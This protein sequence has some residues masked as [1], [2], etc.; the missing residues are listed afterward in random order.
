MNDAYIMEYLPELTG[1]ERLYVHNLMAGMAREQA[2]VFTSEYRRKRK[3][4]QT[5]LLA[6]IV[7]LV[8]CPG[9]QRFWLGET[10]M[11]FLFLFT[12]GLF[13]MGT[14]IDLAT[15]KT[16]ARC[17]NQK[18]SQKIHAEVLLKA[19]KSATLHEEPERVFPQLNRH[20]SV[21]GDLIIQ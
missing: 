10:G 3:D 20:P 18:V 9:F 1:T 16:L 15:Y 17:Y 12:G 11:G 5:V 14:I 6:A 4:P 19:A 7:G 8:G 2:E 21:Y 13:L